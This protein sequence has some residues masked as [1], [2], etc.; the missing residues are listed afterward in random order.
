MKK[1]LWPT[2]MAQSSWAFTSAMVKQHWNDVKRGMGF[3]SPSDTPPSLSGPHPFSRS[4][5]PSPGRQTADGTPADAP[6]SAVSK[7]ADD[8]QSNDLESGGRTSFLKDMAQSHVDGARQMSNGPWMEFRKKLAQTWRPTRDYPPR[9]S[10]MVSGIVEIETPKSFVLVDVHA[11]W[12]PKLQKYDAQSMT[13]NVRRI[14][15]K[16]QSPAVG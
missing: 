6:D 4:N 14:Q 7:T 3:G 13:M 1:I 16:R 2:A 15:M 11:H 5:L 9:G 8:R 12:N 10:I